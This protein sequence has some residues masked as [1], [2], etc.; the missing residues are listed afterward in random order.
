[1]RASQI[2]APSGRRYAFAIDAADRAALLDGTDLVA[3]TLRRSA[4]IEAWE[5]RTRQLQPWLQDVGG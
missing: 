4:D 2:T 5:A 1:L 3:L